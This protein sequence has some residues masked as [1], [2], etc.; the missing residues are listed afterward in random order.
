MRN[1]KLLVGV[2]LLGMVLPCAAAEEKDKS[3]SPVS[4]ADKAAQAAMFDQVVDRIANREQENLK[5]LRKFTPVVETYIQNIKVDPNYGPVTS[6]DK[7]FLGRMDM[8]N[9]GIKNRSYLKQAG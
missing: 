3:T 8:S 9:G 2:L 4:S 6:D 5:E 1:P 7:Y